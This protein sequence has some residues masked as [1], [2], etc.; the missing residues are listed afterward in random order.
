MA[1]TF[2]FVPKEWPNPKESP[3]PPENLWH[4]HPIELAKMMELVEKGRIFPFSGKRVQLFKWFACEKEKGVLRCFAEDEIEVSMLR[5]LV[6]DNGGSDI[7]VVPR[8]GHLDT[9][10]D[11]SQAVEAS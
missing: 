10:P 1:F 3:Q 7:R 4:S 11:S 9:I 5:I 6:E 8:E 2:T